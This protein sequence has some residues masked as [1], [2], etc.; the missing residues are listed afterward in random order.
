MVHHGLWDHDNSSATL[1]IDATIDGKP[2]KLA[3]QPSKQGWLYTFDR[4]TGQPIWPIPEV[5]V[6]QS[7][8]PNEK[9][10]ATQPIPTK[11]PPYSLTFISTDDLIDFTPALRAQALENLKK[12][13]WEQTPFVPPT[14]PNSKF[15]GSVNIGNTAGGIN[16]PGASFDPETATFYGQAKRHNRQF[17][18]RGI[19]QIRVENQK[20]VCLAGSRSNYGLPRERPVAAVRDAV[21]HLKRG[22]VPRRRSSSRRLRR[23]ALFRVSRPPDR[24][25]A[26]G[27][28]RRSISIP[29]H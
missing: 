22:A 13:R 26:H 20:S 2:R 12:Y 4:I 6:P 27:V 11:P 24:Q 28:L 7:D 1:L 18:H 17:R 3:A 10:A 15:L 8:I 5:P 19:Q 23:G 25:A 29:G 21:W 9:T 16:W 14:G